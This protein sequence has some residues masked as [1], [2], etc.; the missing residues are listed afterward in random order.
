MSDLLSSSEFQWHLEAIEQNAPETRNPSIRSLYVH[1]E[2][3]RMLLD[4]LLGAARAAVKAPGT[5][6]TA[7]LA[8][9]IRLTEAHK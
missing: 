4:E 3:Q 6:T 2:T 7:W 9:T 8:R 1:D 5:E